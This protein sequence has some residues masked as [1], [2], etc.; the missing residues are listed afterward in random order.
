MTHLLRPDGP[1]SQLCAHIPAIEALETANPI[2]QILEAARDPETDLIERILELDTALAAAVDRRSF[3]VV[4]EAAR[5][6][7][8]ADL[9]LLQHTYADALRIHTDTSLLLF[10]IIVASQSPEAAHRLDSADYV[11]FSRPL[12]FHFLN[13]ALPGLDLQV[14]LCVTPGLISDAGL[15]PLGSSETTFRLLQAAGKFLSHSES[16]TNGSRIPK[17]LIQTLGLRDSAAIAQFDPV[18]GRKLHLFAWPI[19]LHK[20]PYT[21][22]PSNDFLHHFVRF[23][24]SPGTRT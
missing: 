9:S 18:S 8:A 5:F 14:T 16:L 7:T 24:P 23:R 11:H 12:N 10:P 15:A 4:D 17:F 22:T 19:F 21:Q 6:G 1:L 20:I 2:I 3:A 13:K